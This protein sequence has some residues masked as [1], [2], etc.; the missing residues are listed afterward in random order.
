MN[1]LMFTNTFLPHVGGVARSVQQFA[2]Q[3]R[4]MGHRVIIVA[5]D[6][7]SIPADEHDVIRVPAIQHFNGTDFS[8]PMPV[9]GLLSRALDDITPD[10]VH[11]HHPFLLGDTALRAAAERDVPVVFTHHTQYEQYTHYVPGDSE[12]LK[13][14]VVD[15][16]V[17]YCNMCEAV[18][19]PSE[20]I[21]RRLIEQGVTTDIVEIPTGVD[22]T[23]FSRGDASTWRKRHGIA[24]DTLVVGHV[25]RLAPEKGLEL[26][27]NVVAEFLATVD[28]GLFVVAGT[29]PSEDA[30]R[31]AFDR[32]DL[33]DRLMRFAVLDRSELAHL[34][35]AMDVFAFASLSET[36]GM[37]LTEAMAAGTPVIAIDAPGV[38]EVV[39]D[40]WNG[41]LLPSP[42]TATFVEALRW[43][44]Q[45]DSPA[46][47][48]LT[49]HAKLTAEEFSLPRTAE[50][51]I[52]LY[53]RLIRRGRR[54]DHGQDLWSIARRRIAEEWKIWTNVAT[55]AASAL[56]PG[57]A[58]EDP[59]HLQEGG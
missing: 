46:R 12:M 25:G 6:F 10:I 15:L 13:R 47:A 19:A 28:H 51:A 29:G 52:D 50:R 20:T 57:R 53:A 36:Q 30:I 22:L 32:R 55:A 41:R 11:S 21:R 26:L 39:R 37:V 17:G 2:G 48:A 4:G 9:P 59:S 54:G 49:S 18:I 56:L 7:D 1:I 38:R 45:L 40:G 31:E 24:D 33:G 27:A 35:A 58:A 5:P 23:V 8:V 44:R 3:F 34:Y 14:F 42:D 16:S 43:Y